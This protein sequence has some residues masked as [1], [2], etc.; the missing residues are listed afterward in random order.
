MYSIP[1]SCP[2]SLLL[3]DLFLPPHGPLCTFMYTY[4][5][6]LMN[7]HAILH[8]SPLITVSSQLFIYVVLRRQ[9]HRPF[10]QQ[11]DGYE[12]C[13]YSSYQPK[14]HAYWLKYL[15]NTKVHKLFLR[16]ILQHEEKMRGLGNMGSDIETWKSITAVE[17]IR[18]YTGLEKNLPWAAGKQEVLCGYLR[19]NS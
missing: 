3:L 1:L 15:Q 13:T 4:W 14:V 9:H 19:A 8:R 5:E 16:Y 11:L 17:I 2:P 7:L 10:Q 12:F 6:H 18:V